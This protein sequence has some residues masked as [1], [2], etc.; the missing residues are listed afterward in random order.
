MHTK[1]TTTTLL[2][3]EL[4]YSECDAR[5]RER[6]RRMIRRARKQADKRYGKGHK[7]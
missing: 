4:D 7:R 3:P 5:Q 2:V 6:E 1:T